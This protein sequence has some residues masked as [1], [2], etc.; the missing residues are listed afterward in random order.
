MAVTG[1][2][3]YAH[4]MFTKAVR[5][6]SLI[7]GPVTSTFEKWLRVSVP[8]SIA[9]ACAMRPKTASR[10]SAGSVETRCCMSSKKLS[11]LRAK[12]QASTIAISCSRLSLSAWVRR[13][14]CSCFSYSRHCASHRWCSIS[15]CFWASSR[16]LTIVGTAASNAFTIIFDC[17]RVSSAAHPRGRS[18]LDCSSHT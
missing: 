16:R 1:H 6:L 12:D 8:P 3:R 17:V 2:V 5:R 13:R 15:A 7:V 4:F 10:C 14:S 9:R 11:K 18:E